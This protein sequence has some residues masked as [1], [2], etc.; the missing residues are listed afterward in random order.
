MGRDQRPT[1]G[2]R[3]LMGPQRLAQP[4]AP[5]VQDGDEVVGIRQLALVESVGRL[6]L[7]ERLP[8]RDGTLESFQC[9]VGRH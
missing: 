6:G 4:V 7:P 2:E 9:L 1:E 8:Q 3:L 5:I